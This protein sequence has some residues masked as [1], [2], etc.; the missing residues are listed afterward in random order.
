MWW[1]DRRRVLAGLAGLSAL[2]LPGCGFE[3]VYSGGATGTGMTGRIE[4]ASL[5]G[6]LGFQFREAF[7]DVA[8]RPDNPAYALD[9]TI[10]LDQEG[11]AIASDSSITRYNLS[12]TGRYTVTTRA[13]GLTFSGVARSFTA[14]NATAAPFP[15]RVAQRDAQ[16]RVATDLARRILTD[17]AVAERT[18]ALA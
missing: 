15:T 5:P 8:G 16:R 1:S 10:S 13:T 4:L 18:G 17:I 12:A 14:Y 6:R 7:E 11:R 2:G 9:V 3:P